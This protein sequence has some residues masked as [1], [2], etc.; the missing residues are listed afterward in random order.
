[1]WYDNTGAIFKT[2]SD[3]LDNM[4]FFPSNA[5]RTFSVSVKNSTC[6]S[7]KTPVAY[8]VN[9]SPANPVI[10]TNLAGPVCGGT[11]GFWV[12]QRD[13]AYTAT[14]YKIVNFPT[15]S[16]TISEIITAAIVEGANVTWGFSPGTIAVELTDPVTNCTATGTAELVLKPF[17]ASPVVPTVKI[18][19]PGTATFT[20]TGIPAGD[21][22]YK[23]YSGPG[24]NVLLATGA[25]YDAMI[26]QFVSYYVSILDNTNGCE[27]P[28]VEADGYIDNT[29]A[30]LT[31]PVV[32]YTPS[33]CPDANGNYQITK[34]PGFTYTA[35]FPDG[36][37]IVS[38]SCNDDGNYQGCNY[39]FGNTSGNLI[40]TGTNASGCIATSQNPITIIPIPTVNAVS[41]A[42]ICTGSTT[43]IIL[44]SPTP[45]TTFSWTATLI[46]GS[47]T[48]F[49]DGSGT[50]ISQALAGSGEIRYDVMA[51]KNN[52]HV[53]VTSIYQTVNTFPVSVTVVAN[54]PDVTTT[55][56]ANKIAITFTATAVNAGSSPVYQWTVD[57]VVKGTN[58]PTFTT[59][60]ITFGTRG[61][62]ASQVLCT[63]TS[64]LACA[65]NNPAT[66][67]P[68][69][70]SINCPGCRKGSFTEIETDQTETSISVV[71]NPFS[72]HINVSVPLLD[73]EHAEIIVTD[74][75][76]KVVEQFVS[77]ESQIELGNSW[78]DGLYVLK[79]IVAG[80]TNTYKI[81]KVE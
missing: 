17:P 43:N 14:N 21:Y 36:T 3:Y 33:G 9:Q 78:A 29:S 15:G 45:N 76:G 81:V 22:T 30:S 56:V 19:T 4:I 58:S 34:Q 68:V 57:N 8:T 1:V 28:R 74:L 52:C 23:W 42:D 77:S 18:C 79:V 25:T 6:E 32:T 12:I 69:T 20:A 31:P 61:A 62:I 41:P 55:Q 5:S 46:A 10:F 51:I 50:T 66:S 63:V 59:A 39:V 37:N 67:T 24:N 27:S 54:P 75:N 47:T 7:A 11:S 38:G 35:T 48:G 49:S 73:N 13:G 44:T 2:S 60:N 64:D 26:T 72:G 53:P 71:P 16:Q 70:V 40:V 80:D 65:V